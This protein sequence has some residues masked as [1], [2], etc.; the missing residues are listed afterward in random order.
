MAQTK[1]AHLIIVVVVAKIAMINAHL[2][3]YSVSS[4]VSEKEIKYSI[5]SAELEFCRQLKLRAFFTTHELTHSP[6]N[7]CCDIFGCGNYTYGGH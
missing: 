2:I 5:P 7:T 1:M 6:M 4:L 3:T